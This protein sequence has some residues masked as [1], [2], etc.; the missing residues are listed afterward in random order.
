[1]KQYTIR[2]VPEEIREKV[3][4]YAADRGVSINKAFVHLVEESCGAQKRGRK[5]L[6]DGL[7]KLFGAWKKR[8]A[9][10]FDRSLSEQRQIDEELWRT[11]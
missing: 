10:S 8:D 11:G 5:P 4:R 1:M 9:D 7:M 6:P 2:G 3:S